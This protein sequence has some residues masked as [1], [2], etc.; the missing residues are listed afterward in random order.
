MAPMAKL[1][2]VRA[3]RGAGKRSVILQASFYNSKQISASIPKNG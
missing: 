3:H 2:R 1:N